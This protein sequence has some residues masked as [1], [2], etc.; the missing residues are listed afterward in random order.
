MSVGQVGQAMKY[1]K[2]VAIALIAA[3]CGSVA[4]MAAIGSLDPSSS[5]L[6]D[7]LRSEPASDASVL[8][9]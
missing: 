6:N 1:R 7:V 5:L 8:S 2:H 3:L 4:M 9:W